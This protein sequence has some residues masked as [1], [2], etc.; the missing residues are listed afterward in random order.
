MKLSLAAKRVVAALLAVVAAVVGVWAAAFPASFYADFPLPGRH[1]VSTLGA[2]N[3]H[4]TRDV[5]GLYLGL[6]VL[7]VWAVRRPSVA[8]MSVTGGAWLVFDAQHLLWHSLHLGAFSMVDKVGNVVS[9]VGVLVLS[10][11]L[12]VPAREKA[13][14]S[15]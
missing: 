9:L 14:T 6:L 5:G 8:G 1:W 12:L 4:L 7:T 2:Y 15:Q 3:E 13:P 11:L 10:V